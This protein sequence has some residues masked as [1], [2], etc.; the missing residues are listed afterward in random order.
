MQRFFT[1]VVLLAALL[2]FGVSAQAKSL[3]FAD[4]I[5]ANSVFGSVPGISFIN[6]NTGI[7]SIL[8]EAASTKFDLYL[9]G[10]SADLTS[11]LGQNVSG[12]FQAFQYNIFGFNNQGVYTGQAKLRE[13]LLLSDVAIDITGPGISYNLGISKTSQYYGGRNHEMFDT[14]YYAAPTQTGNKNVDPK[15]Q[16]FVVTDNS[17][18]INGKV[19]YQGSLIFALDDGARNHMDFNDLI[20][21]MGAKTPPAVPAPAAALLLAPGLAGIFALRKKMN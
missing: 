21:V 1:L 7:S 8:S 2:G 19:F 5:T 17:V 16:L 18:E 15:F 14:N 9:L 20:F 12:R 6:S 11:T 3:S 10:K 4:G 13:D